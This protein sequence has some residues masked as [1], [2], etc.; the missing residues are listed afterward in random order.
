MYENLHHYF[1]ILGEELEKLLLPLEQL[2]KPP[3]IFSFC[4]NFKRFLEDQ[5]MKG[6]FSDYLSGLCQERNLESFK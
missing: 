2:T 5:V 3:C 6:Q 1:F 4:R